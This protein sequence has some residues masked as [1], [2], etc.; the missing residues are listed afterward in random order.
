MMRKFQRRILQHRVQ[1]ILSF[2]ESWTRLLGFIS[3]ASFA[4][5]RARRKVRRDDA[6]RRSLVFRYRVE[7]FLCL[8]KIGRIEIRR[9]DLICAIRANESVLIRRWLWYAAALMTVR[10]NHVLRR[11]PVTHLTAL[12]AELLDSFI[13]GRGRRLKRVL[14]AIQKLFIFVRLLA[15]AIGLNLSN[16][17]CAG[18]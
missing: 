3:K 6:I 14:L 18:Y 5:H 17:S 7:L 2:R 9:R 1:T 4:Q 12:G 13:Q 10:K 8:V 15:V 16:G 11:Q